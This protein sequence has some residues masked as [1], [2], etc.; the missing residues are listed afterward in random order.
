MDSEIS[1]AT[2]VLT[3]CGALK[4]PRVAVR[5][6]KDG[7]ST[8]L[9]GDVRCT[10]EDDA[11]KG[12]SNPEPTLSKPFQVEDLPILQFPAGLRACSAVRKGMVILK[13]SGH[14]P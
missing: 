12:L 5:T 7:V 3:A 11:R 10:R 13:V 4:E 9:T 2:S 8:H 1:G 6:P 14:R